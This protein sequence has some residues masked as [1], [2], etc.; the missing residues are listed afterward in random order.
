[1]DRQVVDAGVGDPLGVLGEAGDPDAGHRELGDLFLHRHHHAARVDLDGRLREVAVEE[2][3]QVLVGGD[4]HHHVVPG[5]VADHL[6]GRAVG[7]AGRELLQREVDEPVLHGRRVGGDATRHLRH[8][9]ALEVVRI[10]RPRDH[11]VAVDG[12]R[13]AALFGGPPADPL[14]PRLVGAEHALD[15]AEV[16]RQV[17][18]GQEVDEQRRADGV[19]D[20]GAGEVGVVGRPF[21]TGDRIAAA[22]V[23]DVLVGEPFLGRRQVSFE[24]P[25]HG[26]VEIVEDGLIGAHEVHLIS[27]PTSR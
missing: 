18:L 3:V 24:Q 17:V 2:L 15:G 10:D 9:A 1:M 16:V 12:H 5:R 20:L 11:Q 14:A 13:V 26:G 4:A 19:V 27:L 21:L 25:F 23:R 7:D 22:P 6:A 8:A